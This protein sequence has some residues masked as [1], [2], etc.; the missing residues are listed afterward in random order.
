MRWWG[1]AVN[2][3]GE[4]LFSWATSRWARRRQ[5]PTRGACAGACREPIRG[6]VMLLRGVESWFGEEKKWGLAVAGGVS[7]GWV[8]NED[9]CRLR[10]CRVVL[11]RPTYYK[12]GDVCGR[13]LVGEVL[14]SCPA[15]VKKQRRTTKKIR[16]NTPLGG[17]AAGGGG[18]G[19][20]RLCLRGRL[21]G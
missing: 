9:L 6:W 11:S 10:I 17:G 20:G 15:A 1:G 3:L 8:T 18:G 4:V 12:L 5:R 14:F 2:G 16:S 21:W 7:I 19:R 13:H